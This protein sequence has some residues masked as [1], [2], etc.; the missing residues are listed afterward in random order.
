MRVLALNFTPKGAGTYL[1][2]FY[3]SRELARAGCE[4]TLAT[5]SNRSRF[6]L[7]TSYKRDWVRE[8]D[9]PR[10]NGPWIRM[11]ECP[12]WGNRMLPGS[13]WGALD[14]ACRVREL[15]IG[16]YDAVVGFEYQPNVSWPI[17]LTQSRKAYAFFSD[18]CDWFGGSSNKFRGWKWAHRLDSYFEEKIRFRAERVSV[19]SRVLEDRALSI[20]IPRS[21]VFHIPNGAPTEY[22]VPRS[23]ELARRRFC[24]PEN[25]PVIVAVSN[26]SMCRELLIFSELLRYAPRALFLLVGR[27]SNGALALAERLGLKECLATVGWVSDEDY[28]WVLSCADV[29]ICPLE[30]ALNDRARWPA[31][32]LDYLT[33]GRPTVTNAV[34]EVGTLFRA[35]EVG[36]L[37]GHSTEEFAGEI[38]AL[39]QQPDRRRYL[40]ESARNVMVQEWDWRIRGPQIAAMVGA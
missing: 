19:T 6:R 17:Y 25:S 21:S 26:G 31:K 23:R 10:G 36:V 22:I 39:L 24:L 30:D 16:N 29:C 14:I 3:F 2:A 28:P 12:A 7:S 4:V 20:G 8:F 13:G 5:V 9:E 11:L 1:R 18:W 38:Y 32:I 35:S 27:I 40:G 34:G 33:A 15:E 37:A